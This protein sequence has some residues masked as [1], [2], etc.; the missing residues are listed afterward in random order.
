MD[1]EKKVPEMIQ[2]TRTQLPI[3]LAFAL[4]TLL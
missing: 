1:K 4:T 3:V 2:V